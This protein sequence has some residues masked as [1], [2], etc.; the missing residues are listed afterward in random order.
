MSDQLTAISPARLLLTMIVV[1]AASLVCF[2][3]HSL[4]FIA[5]G[6]VRLSLTSLVSIVY[7]LTTIYHQTCIA[8][9]S[10]REPSFAIVIVVWML[11]TI[12]PGTCIFEPVHRLGATLR[13][14][15]STIKCIIQR[16]KQTELNVSLI[17]ASLVHLRRGGGQLT[18]ER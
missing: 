18:V 15:C 8:C 17:P 4:S 13:R 9:I 2:S 3:V 10:I 11:G 1:F 5:C 14:R 7:P 6:S 16:I 12:E